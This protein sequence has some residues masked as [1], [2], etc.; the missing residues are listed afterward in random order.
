[1]SYGNKNLETWWD[2]WVN[3]ETNSE[4]PTTIIVNYFGKSLSN[5]TKFL[6]IYD[7]E[8]LK[9]KGGAIKEIGRDV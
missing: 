1:M 6:R 2:L 3:R 9:D 7:T 8:D 4:K 5:E